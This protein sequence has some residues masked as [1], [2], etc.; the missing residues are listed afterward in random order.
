MAKF[1]ST[2]QISTTCRLKVI[3]TLIHENRHFVQDK[4]S[5][6]STAQKFA[7]LSQKMFNIFSL[8]NWLIF[9]QYQDKIKNGTPLEKYAFA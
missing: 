1:K 7:F 3:S 4:L 8:A 6:C 5:P 2:L 9:E